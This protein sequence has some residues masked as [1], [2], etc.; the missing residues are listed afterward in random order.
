M[1]ANNTCQSPKRVKM[2]LFIKL[3]I[4]VLPQ[5]PNRRLFKIEKRGT[6]TLFASEVLDYLCCQ[7]NE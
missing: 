2:Y 6:L 4:C 3:I 5:V 1:Y 7:I